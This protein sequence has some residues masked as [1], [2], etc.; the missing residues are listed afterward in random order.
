MLVSIGKPNDLRNILNLK[1]NEFNLE[2]FML[3]SIA[4]RMKVIWIR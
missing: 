3:N 1:F 2:I 4:I